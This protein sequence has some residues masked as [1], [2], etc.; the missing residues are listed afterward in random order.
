V[1]NDP[2][3]S[4]SPTSPFSIALWFKETGGQSVYHILGKRVGCGGNSI[5]INYQLS[6]GPTGG[7]E[8]NA[9]VGGIISTNVQPQGCGAVPGFVGHPLGAGSP[10]V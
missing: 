10:V 8:F 5:G 1:P 9:E 6:C 2:A 3:L 7:I 4:F